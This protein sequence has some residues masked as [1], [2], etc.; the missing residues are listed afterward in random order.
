MLFAQLPLFSPS[1]V[2]LQKLGGGG[3]RHPHRAAEAFL[4]VDLAC[5]AEDVCSVRRLESPTS[6]N[7]LFDLA[8]AA[9]TVE[10]LGSKQA[11]ACSYCLYRMS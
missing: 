6:G 1:Q 2:E 7:V 8:H 5:L 10:L 11:I 4:W 9:T 3:H